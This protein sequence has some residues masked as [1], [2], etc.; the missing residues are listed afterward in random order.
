M[1]CIEAS[2][3]ISE[4]VNQAVEQ[5]DNVFASFLDVRKAFD[6]VW[7]D[8]L[9]F[10]LYEELSIDFG[11]WLIIRDLYQG[12]QANVIHGG[13]LSSISPISQ[14]SGQGRILALFMYKV[15]INSLIS[16]ICDLKLGICLTNRFGSAPTFADDM[17]LLGLHASALSTLIRCAYDYC[18]KWRYEYHNE[19]SRIV[20]F[21]E[22]PA[23]HG[24][25]INT[26]KFFIGSSLTEE[27]K[28]YTNLGI[29]KNYCG[30]FVTNSNENITKAKEKAGMLF[31]ARFDRR[32]TNPLVYLKIW[33]QA[34]IPCLLFGS[35]LWNLTLSDIE[36]LERCQR[37]FVR[38]VFYLP[39]HSDGFSLQ[40]I[41]GLTSVELVIDIRKLFFFVRI[42]RNDGMSPVVRDIFRF[43]AKKY[44]R[45]PDC[46]PT[47]FMGDIVGLLKKCDLHSYFIM[48]I[49]MLT[50]FHPVL[51]GKGL[52]IKRSTSMIKRNYSLMLLNLAT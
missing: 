6:T 25:M 11:L 17:T 47:G 35:E 20:V 4:S 37:W 12:L 52:S 39:D 44:Y 3:V 8:G 9:L 2:C 40:S 23:M 26:R 28:E 29:Y 22:T 45:N 10:K 16:K 46:I 36:K 50:Y 38:K 1:G 18:C 31:S 49:N 24:R 34:C 41:S 48:C 13:Q 33:K 21:G 42:V 7:H 15:Y 43:R 14:G 30:S 51:P 32:R 19:K 5:G 27:V